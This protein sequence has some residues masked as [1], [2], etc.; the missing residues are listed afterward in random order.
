MKSKLMMKD[1]NPTR[2]TINQKKNKQ[3]NTGFLQ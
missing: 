3:T 1:I 2:V